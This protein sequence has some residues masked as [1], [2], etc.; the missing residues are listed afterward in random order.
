MSDFEQK[1][2]SMGKTIE[3]VKKSIEEL[4]KCY[5][6]LKTSYEKKNYTKVFLRFLKVIT[7]D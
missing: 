6:D 2:E 7:G 3:N 1:L 4:E 5:I